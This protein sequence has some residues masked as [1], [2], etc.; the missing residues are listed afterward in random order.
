MVKLYF[1]LIF[2]VVIIFSCRQN[3]NKKLLEEI[4]ILI[5][6]KE[7]F[8]TIDSIYRIDTYDNYAM[9]LG[10][11]GSKTKYLDRLLKNPE[12]IDSFF[13]NDDLLFMKK[14]EARIT[15]FN[16]K[17]EYFPGKVI[18]P[19]DTL[20]KFM[21]KDRSV[22]YKRIKEKYGTSLF[23]VISIPLFS[24][25]RKTVLIHKYGFGHGGLYIFKKRNNNWIKVKVLSEWEE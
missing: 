19:V 14:Q 8:N 12:R 22:Y 3:I 24:I 9:T 1:I 16:L 11:V 20:A 10:L 21:D 23:N 5:P 17:P 7:L 13:S 15:V 2:I 6:E 4:P 18:I 25:D